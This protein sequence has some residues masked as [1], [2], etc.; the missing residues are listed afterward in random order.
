MTHTPA[1]LRA[2]LPSGS[3]GLSRVL[4][5]GA[6]A[7]LVEEIAREAGFSDATV[8]VTGGAR[9]FLERPGLFGSRQVYVYSDLVHLGLLAAA[10]IAAELQEESCPSESAS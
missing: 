3:D 2:L 4:V 9:A 10:G 1:P 8:A 7:Q 6:A 5:G